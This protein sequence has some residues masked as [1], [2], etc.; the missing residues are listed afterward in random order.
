MVAVQGEQDGVHWRV[1][2]EFYE[3]GKR[4]SYFELLNDV[5]N[6]KL[7]IAKMMQCNRKVRITSGTAVWDCGPVMA[8]LR[9]PVKRTCTELM[10]ANSAL[11]ARC[12]C[13]LSACCCRRWQ[14]WTGGQ[15]GW[16]TLTTLC[17][18]LPIM[19]LRR[20]LSASESMD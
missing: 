6:R 5:T 13:V 11:I 20:Q 18:Q 14:H 1:P 12:Q 10:H 17:H 16:M 15:R 7:R 4:M 3:E 2:K 8:P 19:P 9:A